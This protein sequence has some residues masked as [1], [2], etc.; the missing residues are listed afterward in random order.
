MQRLNVLTLTRASRAAIKEEATV[1]DT[2]GLILNHAGDNEA[3]LQL[4]L[5]C[6]FDRC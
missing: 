4:Y 6:I 1:V 2:S 5:Y 3:V